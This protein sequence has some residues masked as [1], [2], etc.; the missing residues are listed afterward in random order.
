MQ[1]WTTG[2]RQCVAGLALWLLAAA[3]AIAAATPPAPKTFESPEAAMNQFGD[4]ITR[5]DEKA[6][7][8]ILGADF[9]DLVPP[10]DAADRRRFV[11]AWNEAHAIKPVN[12]KS[13]QITVGK[14]GWTLPVPLTKFDAGWRFDTVA[15]AEVVRERRIGRNELAAMQVLLAVWDAQREYASEYRDKDG[16]LK[17][18]A[19]LKSSPGKRDG[20]YWPTKAG[21][22]QSPIGKIAADAGAKSTSPDGYHGYHYKLLTAQGPNARGGAYDYKVKDKLLGGFGVLAWPVRYWDTGVMSFIVNHDGTVFETDLGPDTAKK[23]AAMKSF[24]PGPGWAVVT[25]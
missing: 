8:E 14:D 15:G 17:Y 23:A 1:A 21:E 16:L 4:A 11:A 9:L 25:P 12:D 13:A 10:I 5:S 3:A 19:K 18:A 22:P 6:L 7:K 20:L 2:C 24:D